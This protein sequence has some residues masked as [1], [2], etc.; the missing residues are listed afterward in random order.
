MIQKKVE[1]GVW[2]PIHINKGGPDISYLL[3]VVF[4]NGKKSQV[5]CVTDTLNEFDEM[6][7]VCINL[8][9]SRAMASKYLSSRKGDSLSWF[10]SICFTSDIG[11]YLRAPLL[12]VISLDLSYYLTK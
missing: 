7:R 4:C 3:F 2:K 11:R 12:K 8:D 6:S 9:K 1:N 10:T 5:K